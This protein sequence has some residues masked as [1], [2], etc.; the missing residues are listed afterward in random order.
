MNGHDRLLAAFLAGDLDLG[1]ARRWDEHLLDCEQCWRAV[2][3]DRA[4]RQAAGLLRQPAPDGLA[5]RVAFAVELAAAGAT[6]PAPPRR[7]A[8]PRPGRLTAAGAPALGLAGSLAVL[9]FP[10]G[11]GSL[12][13]P[14]AAVTRY[15]ETVPPLHRPGP[16]PGEQA[17]PVQVGHPV[18]VT[19]NGHPIV[20]RTWRLGGTEVVVATSGRPFPMPPG[21]HGTSA[22]GMAWVARAGNLSLYCI[23][24]PTSELLAAAIPAGELAARAARRP[25][26]CPAAADLQPLSRATARGHGGRS[27]APAQAGAER[28]QPGLGQHRPHSLLAR[29]CNQRRY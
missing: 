19:A 20:V 1:E 6:S 12:P 27:Q 17:A 15:A 25:A 16:G 2:R 3:E 22:G 8:R 11:H 9:L 7:R 10:G 14:V 4:G 21:A 13:A 26:A 28:T 29:M 24:G 18:T 23:N 5:D